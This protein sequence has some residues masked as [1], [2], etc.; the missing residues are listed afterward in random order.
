M[1]KNL[2]EDLKIISLNIEF[3]KHYSLIFPFFF[4][5]NPDVIL[6][7]EVLEEDLLLFQKNLQMDFVFVPLAKIKFSGTVKILGIAT[8]SK[9]KIFKKE[10]LYFRGDKKKIPTLDQT[11]PEKMNR[12]ILVTWIKKSSKQFVC[13]NTHFTWTD[14]GVPT[15]VQKDDLEK[16]LKLLKNYKEF[17]LCGDFNAPRGREVFDKLASVYKDNIPKNI[18]TTIDKDIHRAGDL[19]VVVD[20]LFTTK[21]YLAEN[22]RV[23][24]GVSDH[25]VIVSSV[26]K[27]RYTHQISKLD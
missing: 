1:Q 23:V 27:D 22:V 14:G 9:F 2:S 26:D 16:M 19:K 13:I 24:G 15:K 4:N 6:L 20:G 7:Q 8:F 10:V 12:A 11:E 17:V 25:M 18:A 21:E 5:E 3:N